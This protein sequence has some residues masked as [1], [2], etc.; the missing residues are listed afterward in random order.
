MIKMIRWD[1]LTFT[2]LEKLLNDKTVV[3]LPIGSVEEHGA[4]LPLSSDMIQPNYIA[5][6]VSDRIGA[7]ILP[8][9]SYG[10]TKT[11]NSF[12]GTI[13]INFETL[14]MLTYDILN[15]VCKA[16]VKNIVILSGHASK[17]HMAALNL[18]A[19]EILDTYHIKIM[20]L[21][22]YDIAYEY[23]GRLVPETDSHAGIIETSRVMAIAPDLVKKDWK[24]E[25]KKSE[26]KYMVLKDIREYYTYG[27]LSDPDGASP[28]LGAQ[29]NKLILDRL[30]DYIKANFEL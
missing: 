5:E 9:I 8:P 28:E 26:K 13:S 18:A 6:Q 21:S 29:L 2:E 15:A 22:D 24:Y 7:I 17:L 25:K 20:V 11:M 4:H 27:T 10:W 23:R 30:I 3:I 14:K 1:N 19:D 12:K 16:G